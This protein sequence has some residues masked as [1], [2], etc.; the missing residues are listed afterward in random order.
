MSTWEQWGLGA[1]VLI[2]SAFCFLLLRY[3]MRLDKK[4]EELRRIHPESLRRGIS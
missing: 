1:V 2:N 3:A 4:V